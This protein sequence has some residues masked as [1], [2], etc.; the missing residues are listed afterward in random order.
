MHPNIGLCCHRHPRTHGTRLLS[1]SSLSSLLSPLSPLLSP[2]LLTL[3]YCLFSR[4][5]LFASLSSRSSVL[6]LSS[7]FCLPL[8]PPPSTLCSR[9]HTRAHPR[10]PTGGAR[11]GG[12]V[13]AVDAR[14]QRGHGARDEP[15]HMVPLRGSGSQGG[16]DALI[17]G[18]E[19]QQAVQ[20]LQQRFPPG[21]PR[22]SQYEGG[23]QVLFQLD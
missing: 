8:S 2:Y 22:T 4:C 18:H 21:I 13:P 12:F 19:P 10:R 5:S 14:G 7:L 20:A 1:L 16:R 23:A 6:Y 9:T 3:P 17:L 11:K 15:P